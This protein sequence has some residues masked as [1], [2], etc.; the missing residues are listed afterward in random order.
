MSQPGDRGAVSSGICE[1]H[2]VEELARAIDGGQYHNEQLGRGTLKAELMRIG[3]GGSTLDS[4]IYRP[5]LRAR[6]GMP[7]DAITL[8]YFAAVPGD[9]FL[10]GRKFA[11]PRAAIVRPGDTL[12]A[13]APSGLHWFALTVPMELLGRML[14]ATGQDPA[15]LESS[16][17]GLLPSTPAGDRYGRMLARV[18]RRAARPGRVASDE[19]LEEQLILAF[20]EGMAEGPKGGGGCR[21]HRLARKAEDWMRERLT[22]RLSIAE[23]CL[24]CRCGRRSLEYAFA[25]VFG[26]GPAAYFRSLRLHRA[27]EQLGRHDPA[28]TTVTRI[29]SDLGFEQLGRFAV[30]Y[31]K[32]F[33][34]S[35]RDRLRRPAGAVGSLVNR[36]R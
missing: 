25:S 36:A 8:G 13:I 24:H 17:S 34:E 6:G 19:D 7:P 31:R 9:A 14:E 22:Q 18:Y 15:R 35:P 21:S 33:G 29:A 16:D 28:A 30:E 5:R 11:S 23:L 1:I 2:G 12:D 3:L 32:L 4:G 10:Q 27:H 20:V 26:M